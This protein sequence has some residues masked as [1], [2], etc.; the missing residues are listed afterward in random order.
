MFIDPPKNCISCPRLADFRADNCHS[1]PVFY[2]APV[3]SFGGLDA[4]L[5]IVG[6]APGLKGANATGRPFTGDYAGL[7]L[8]NAL[9]KA[10]FARGEY[11]ARV[12]D[13]LELINCRISNALRCV[14]PENKPSL[15]EIKACNS[16]LQ[17][18]IAAMPNLKVIL[19]LGQLSHNA[20]LRALGLKTS[21]A[22]FTHS[23][24]HKLLT[25]R[26]APHSTFVLLNSYHTSRYNMNVG[27]L[28]VAMF[29]EI[30]R[31]AK[32]LII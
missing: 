2:N 11:Q 23:A 14:P 3:P 6:L 21:S 16:F 31:K 12:D 24:A 10:G 30:I 13:G 28:T 9:L 29:D 32:S 15:S 27:T 18:E 7:I 26:H 4:P 20:V 25:T 8:Y 22:K 1:F 5:L 19:S 17:Q